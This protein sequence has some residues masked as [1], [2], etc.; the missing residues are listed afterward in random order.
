MMKYFLTI[1]ASTLLLQAT[2]VL[3]LIGIQ[4]A[5]FGLLKQKQMPLRD[6]L[7]PGLILIVIRFGVLM[8]NQLPICVLFHRSGIIMTNLNLP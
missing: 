6:N 2:E 1:I 8:V 3:I 4:T 7:P 5:T